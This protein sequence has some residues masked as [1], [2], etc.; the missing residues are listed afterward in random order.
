[1]PARCECGAPATQLAC[2]TQLTS[3]M[4]EMPAQLPVCDACGE[5]MTRD[6]RGVT[7]A[8]LPSLEVGDST[9]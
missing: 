9:G 1:M 3:Q 4:H 8:P 2:F 7:L 6:D 5:E